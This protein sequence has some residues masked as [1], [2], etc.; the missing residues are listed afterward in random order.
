[1][2][3]SSPPIAVG[4]AADRQKRPDRAVVEAALR[5]ARAQLMSGRGPGASP[6]EVAAHTRNRAA[7]AGVST[8]RRLEVQA[9]QTSRARGSL[10]GILDAVQLDRAELAIA[11]RRFA[12]GGRPAAL[13]ALAGRRVVAAML[14][15]S[16]AAAGGLLL[17]LVIR[18]RRQR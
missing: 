5:Q 1:M 14:R 2:I 4:W 18:R 17:A 7:I 11:L 9:R 6:V 15:R 16:G 12:T 10:D 8:T 3:E 13:L